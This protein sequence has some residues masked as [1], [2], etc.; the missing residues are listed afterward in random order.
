[1][2]KRF[3]GDRDIGRAVDD[4]GERLPA[5]L[6]ALARIAFN[7]RWSW[8]PRGAALFRDL[9]PLIWR[10]GD[11]NPRF[12][13]QAVAA[14]RLQ[15]LAADE[16]Y[17]ELL[18]TI[19]GILEHERDWPIP[20]H[21]ATPERPI[22]YFCSEFAI[23]CSLPL[24]GGGLG[25][26]AGDFLK[27][28]SDLGAP[29]IGVGLLYRQG[30]FQQRLDASG[31]QLEYWTTTPFDLLPIVLVTGDDG[32][33]LSVEVPYDGRSVRLQ[34]WR[35]DVGRSRLY[36]LD[37]DR[38]D[39]EVADRFITSRLYVGDPSMRLAQ[40]LMLGVGGVRALAAMG[41][42]P[43]VVHL[44]EGHA[45][46]GAFERLGQQMRGGSS[47]EDALEQVRATTVFTTHTP[48]AAGNEVYS[49]GEVM[50]V[51]GDSLRATGL[52]VEAVL[53]LGRP[54]ADT[55]S[56]A[57][58]ITPLALRTSGAA[59]AVA[60]RHGE[61]ARAMWQPLWPERTVEQVPIGHVTNGVHLGSWMASPVQDLFDRHL[62]AGWR[63]EPPESAVWHG[64]ESIPD[65]EIWRV[66]CELR[67][68]L[69]EYAREVSVRDRLSRGDT[70]EYVGAA[71]RAFDPNALTI[72]FAR[73]VATYKRLYLLTQ[74]P[75]ERLLPLLR[76]TDRPIQLVVAGKAHPRDEE[77]KRALQLAFNVKRFPEIGQRVVYLE[78]YDLHMAPRIV[79]GVDLW[80]NLPRPPLE[81]SGTSGMKVALNGGLNLSV[82]DGWWVE[83][84]RPDI[85]WAIRSPDADAAAQD[86]HDAAALLD[87]LELEVVPLFYQRD[88]AGLPAQWLRRVKSALAELVPRFSARRML[89]DYAHT[90]YAR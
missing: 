34:I 46:F 76:G 36:L 17:V 56:D 73:R 71:A 5:P 2:E 7:Y 59:N 74:L 79:A 24:Y 43:G 90:M 41:I 51:I 64:I 68:Q 33:P 83:G 12:V 19:A 40:Y 78:D 82:L 52:D 8:A 38:Q 6:K 3:D 57:V 20:A 39:N 16:N 28:A 67:R 22:A 10:R 11:C 60:R 85:G 87:L 26:L 4:L 14:R 70:P 61:V 21:A 53:A 29:T 31:W 32:R 62:G 69:V 50:K 81:A 66:R 88:A 89:V 15:Q 77:A 84:Y 13:I 45:A 48:V 65:E 18:T 1:M 80:L 23:H 37:A 35:V 47:F 27:A 75:T 72:G 25:V 58:G 55:A 9:D 54:V 44:N 86:A 30:Y 63:E 49:R 42:E